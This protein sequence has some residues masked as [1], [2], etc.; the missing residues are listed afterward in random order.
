MIMYGIYVL[1]IY[2]DKNISFEDLM[3]RYATSFMGCDFDVNNP[4]P[5]AFIMDEYTV[6]KTKEA[7]DKLISFFSTTIT[8]EQAELAYKRMVKELEEEKREIQLRNGR[9]T[10]SLKQMLIKAESWIPPTDNH[11]KLKEF[12]I[13]NLNKNIMYTNENYKNEIPDKCKWIAE[14]KCGKKLMDDL[15]Y[16]QLRYEMDKTSNSE[17]TKWV[18]E[19]KKSLGIQPNGICFKNGKIVPMEENEVM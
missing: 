6:E 11:R 3:M 16:S 14:Y 12:V 5:D 10:T 1:P 13:E 7:R 4:I 2:D 8:D 18:Q 17:Y 19:L 15:V 9:I